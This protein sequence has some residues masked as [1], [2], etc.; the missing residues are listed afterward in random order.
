MSF[1]D[2]VSIALC[3]YNGERF[4][5]DQ[6]D[7]LVNQTYQNLEIIVVDDCSTDNTVKII[8]DYAAKH[9]FI[10]VFVN[11]TNLGFTRNFEKAITLCSGEY[12]A[13]CDQD[14][15]WDT[16]KIKELIQHSINKVLVY[17][18]S[19]LIDEQGN[20]LEKR[21]SHRFNMF[22]GGDPRPLLLFNCISGHAMLFERKL[23]PEI[24]PIAFS[25]Y[26]DWWIAYVAANIG[27][28]GY[29]DKCLVSY[30]QHNE[31]I[32][33]VMNLK[34]EKKKNEWELTHWLALCASFKKNKH[35]LFVENIN[36]LYEHSS[37]FLNF[38]KVAFL[39]KN[40]KVLLRLQKKSRLSKFNYVLKQL[41]H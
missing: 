18:D 33:D 32:S 23:V 28:I 1:I 7:S 41:W 31:S 16:E 19:M 15:I 21:I 17:H 29:V 35:S 13:L 25:G 12:I 22:E 38:S 34:K 27:T 39:L 4:L 14:D 2:K 3:T 10:K 11:E 8:N 20:S 30:R 26:H 5:K 24:I 36:R 40:N 9:K 37:S 6:L